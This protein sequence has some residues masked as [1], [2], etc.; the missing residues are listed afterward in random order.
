M[1]Y[2]PSDAAIKGCLSLAED[3]RVSVRK[4]RVLSS[5]ARGFDDTR[6]TDPD[7]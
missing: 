3:P 2:D 6:R 7:D 5:R 1:P 4:P